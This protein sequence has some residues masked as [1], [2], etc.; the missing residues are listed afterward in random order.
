MTVDTAPDGVKAGWHL[1]LVG[2]IAL[3]WNG[4]GCFDYI[5]T[6]T[7]NEAYLKD[8]PPEML[9]YWFAMPWWMFGIWAV[10]VFG[11]FF[12]SVAL[13]MKNKA[14][15][16]LF[17]AAFIASVISMY[18]TVTAKDAPKMEGQEFFPWVIMGLGL[19]FFAYAYWQSRR[20][21]L[22]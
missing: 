10:G 2:I 22:R 7:K 14:A 11:A 1:W 16:V 15:V 19:A 13:L 3:L 5:M 9:A 21:I 8:Y 18:I 6:V 12:G 20:G 4:Y 17:A